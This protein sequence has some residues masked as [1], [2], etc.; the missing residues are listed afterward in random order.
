MPYQLYFYPA[1]ASLA[2]HILLEEIGCEYELVLVDRAANAHKSDAYLRLNPAGLIP[3]LR[4]SRALSVPNVI[5]GSSIS[6]TPYK[7]I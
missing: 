4:R 2:P 5:D 7:Q 3:V 1:N 6:P